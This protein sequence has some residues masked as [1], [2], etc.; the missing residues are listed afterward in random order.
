MGQQRE[1]VWAVLL[2]LC[3]L[4]VVA[5]DGVSLCPLSCSH[6]RPTKRQR[7]FFARAPAHVSPALQRPS[8]DEGGGI[9]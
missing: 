1:A 2:C 4:S 5:C 7:A 9:P 3:L 8:A 6:P